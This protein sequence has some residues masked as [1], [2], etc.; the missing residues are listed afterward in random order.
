MSGRWRDVAK[1]QHLV[2]PRQ[3]E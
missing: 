2:K 1:A 3:A